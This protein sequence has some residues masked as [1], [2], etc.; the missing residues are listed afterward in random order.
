[1]T[2]SDSQ[3]SIVPYI[4][5]LTFLSH[6]AIPNQQNSLKA[7]S[8]F[9]QVVWEMMPWAKRNGTEVP[10]YVLP[11]YTSV[12]IDAHFLQEQK[13]KHNSLK[14]RKEKESQAYFF[15]F[16]F[17]IGILFLFLQF[18]VL[19]RARIIKLESR[20]HTYGACIFH[21]THNRSLEVEHY[22]R[23]YALTI[24]ALDFIDGMHGT[25]HSLVNHLNRIQSFRRGMRNQYYI[26]T[27]KQNKY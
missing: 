19:S 24:R 23:L 16:Y 25:S 11:Q 20:A 27:H 18:V 12:W 3:A 1:M 5:R 8:I 4:A 10:T 14:K 21:S 2:N 13:V 6:H 7:T 9:Y 15:S 22:V 26:L 17:T